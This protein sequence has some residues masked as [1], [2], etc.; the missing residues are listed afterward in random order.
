MKKKNIGWHR[1]N[2]SKVE[3][4][5]ERLKWPQPIGPQPP[6]DHEAMRA[7]RRPDKPRV[8]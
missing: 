7:K 6:I 1:S 8:R 2:E 3:R 5:A 4:A